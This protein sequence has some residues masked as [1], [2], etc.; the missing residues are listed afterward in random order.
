MFFF[1]LLPEW[2]QWFLDGAFCQ[3][4]FVWFH[5]LGGCAIGRVARHFQWS[6]AWV[7]PAMLLAAILWE[8]GED[9]ATIR[10][11][12]MGQWTLGGAL[13][14]ICNRDSI[15]DVAGAVIGC[16]LSI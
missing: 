8:I 5:I 12:P 13:R 4:I 11:T 9:Y 3:N 14:R 15:G 10:N 2:L 6:A 7:L 1:Y 16:A